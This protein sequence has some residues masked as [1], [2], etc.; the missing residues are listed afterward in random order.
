VFGV[1]PSE[2]VTLQQVVASRG[3]S[4]LKLKNQGY[5]PLRELGGRLIGLTSGVH[6]NGSGGEQI[7]D[8]LP[9]ETR[10]YH[11]L[12]ESFALTTKWYSG[13]DFF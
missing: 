9:Q 13:E 11:L 6:S 7:I 10:F 8:L 3:T 2:K 5:R 12:G 1:S 4:L